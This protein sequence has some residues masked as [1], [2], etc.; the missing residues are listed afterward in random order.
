MKA[1]NKKPKK[2]LTFEEKKQKVAKLNGMDDIFFQ[3][4]VE[5]IEV[6]EEILRIILEDDSLVVL[7]SHVQESLKNLQGKSVILDVLCR[8]KDGRLINVEVQKSDDTNHTKRVRYN[9][10]LVTSNVTE[11]GEDYLFVPDVLIIFISQF[12]VF[13]KGKTIYHIDRVIR[14]T[15]DVTDNGFSEIYVNTKIDD[16]SNIAQLMQYLK[17]SQGENPVCPKVVKRV[18]LFKES[19]EGVNYMCN[20]MKEE[21]L[22]GRAEGRLEGICILIQTYKE[23]KQSFEDTVQNIA[24]KYQLSEEEAREIVKENW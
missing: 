14:E 20:V 6:L 23:F 17:N 7:E 9:G 8:V 21:R 5:D 2:P 11:I 1:T 13:M 15:G 3:K 19:V 4:L 10:S 12:D 24:K 16:G 22:A 18:K